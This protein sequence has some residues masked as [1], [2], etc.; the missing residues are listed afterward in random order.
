MDI[1]INKLKDI[2]LLLSFNIITSEQVPDLI[3]EYLSNF[4][5][6]FLLNENECLLELASLNKPSLNEVEKLIFKAFEIPKI[7]EYEKLLIIIYWYENNKISNIVSYQLIENL[8]YNIRFELESFENFEREFYNYVFLNRI[9]YGNDWD[10]DF[11]KIK[12][13]L[14]SKIT[15]FNYSE[16]IKLD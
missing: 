4:S 5:K 6:E 14:F 8:D 11:S 16:Y 3:I 15:I 10:E 13:E 1:K 7:T 9:V 12:T 2:Y